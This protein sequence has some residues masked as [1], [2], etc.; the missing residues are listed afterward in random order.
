MLSLYNN[1]L[2]G[3]LADEMGLGK[4]V[5]VILSLMFGS[6]FPYINVLIMFLVLSHRAGPYIRVHYFIYARFIRGLSSFEP[7]IVP[8]NL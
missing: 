5:Q 7:V 4:T 8:E 1:K 6:Y 2:N 3:I